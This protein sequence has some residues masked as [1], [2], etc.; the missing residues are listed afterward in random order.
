MATKILEKPKSTT[1]NL[2]VRQ[3]IQ[4]E[5]IIADKDIVKPNP[6]ANLR[7]L[8]EKAK[9]TSAANFILLRNV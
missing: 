3:K 4:K 7:G 1:S 2:R 6:I 8:S 9:I 5:I